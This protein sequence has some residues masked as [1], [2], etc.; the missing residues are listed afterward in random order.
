MRLTVLAAVLI[1]GLG[2]VYAR[3]VVEAIVAVVND[4]VITLSEYRSEYNGLYESL[5]AQVPEDQFGELWQQRREALL[6]QMITS[7]L[8]LQEARRKGINVAE[9]LRM[10]ID[11]I[12]TENNLESDARLI[13]A[14]QAQGL[15]F[16]VWKS[17]LEEDILRQGVIYS[18]VRSS[19]V[20]DDSDI[21]EYYN[22]HPEEFTD[23]LEYTLKAVFVSKEGRSAEEAESRRKE[24]SDK[25]A[26]GSEMAA[27]VEEYSEGPEKES[28][29]DLG[30]FKT[31]ELAANLESQVKD[32]QQ[33]Q[34]SDWI[35]VGT[36]WY[37][38]Q[39]TERK[40]PRLNSFEESRE[41]IQER[42]YQQAEQGKLEEFITKL[43]ETSFIKIMMENPHET[44]R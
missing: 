43:K 18:E 9:Q 29:G 8:L 4:E 30:S 23:P 10:T 34:L 7:M 21:V 15:D 6:D 24:I 13:Q 31:G 37:L 41:A 2:Q 5:R 27:V 32:L 19:L 26:E 22:T 16:E 44:I 12:K 39:L 35:D 3:Q 17:R 40:E 36:G 38:I 33:G 1:A 14:L 11:N 25:L 20:F 42:L 28:G